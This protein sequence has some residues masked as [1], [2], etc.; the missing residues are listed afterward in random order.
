MKVSA[1]KDYDLCLYHQGTNFY[2]Y[3]MLGSSFCDQE[4]CKSVEF[5]SMGTSC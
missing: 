3:Q 4:S 2:V 5:C 1:L